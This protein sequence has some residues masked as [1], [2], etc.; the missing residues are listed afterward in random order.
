MLIVPYK[1]ETTFTR[2]PYAN[3]VLMSATSILFFVTS[4]FLPYGDVSPYVLRDWSAEG[5][6]GSLFLH[7]GFLH[8]LGNMIFLWIFG[9]AICAAVGNIAYPFIY[10]CLGVFAGIVHLSADAHAAIG[11]SGAINGLVGMTLILFPRNKLHCWYWFFVPF[12]WLWKTG[13]FSVQTFWMI[14]YW[15]GFDILGTM[16]SND[17]VGHWAH[18]GGFIGGII[19]A[20]CALKLK[21]VESYHH[22]LM[23]VIAGRSEED[24]RYRTNQ[25]EQQ[26]YLRQ[27]Q[28]MGAP[29]Q[30]MGEQ[31]QETL[32]AVPVPAPTIQ[33]TV[34]DI[35]LRKCV[36]GG[37][38]ITLYLMNQGA[39][40]H[41]MT[42]RAPQGV[43][44]QMNQSKSLRQG[45][46]G[47]IRFSTTDTDIDSIEFI[48]T[49]QNSS[50]TPHKI[51]F[52]CVPANAALSVVSSA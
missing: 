1:M 5:L 44:V 20:Y 47:W 24:D 37:H 22:T 41:S 27:P 38:M 34:P 43:T 4:F 9:N 8:L 12:L 14:L 19:L 17:G 46:S 30:L 32:T 18:I 36:G 3:A 6:I 31:Q 10:L 50:K 11:A 35:Q 25:L 13:K 16:F 40:M 29:L 15:F 51:R 45:E 49:Y 7:G 26:V 48:V 33:P 52:R 28:E 21:L 42:V 39:P 23:D 2:V